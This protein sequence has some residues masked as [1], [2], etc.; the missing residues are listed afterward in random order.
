VALSAC[1]EKPAESAAESRDARVF[2]LRASPVQVTLRRDSARSVSSRVPAAGGAISAT[3]SDGSRFTLT[4]PPRALDGDTTITLTPISAL[5][6]LPLKGGLVAG[7]HL[8]PE[9]LRFNLPAVLRI[10]PAREAPVQQ[11][12][13]FGYLGGGDDFHAYPLDQGR[14]NKPGY[15]GV[16]TGMSFAQPDPILSSTVERTNYSQFYKK[17]VIKYALKVLP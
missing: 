5:G 8:E 14:E 17:G 16:P 2:P 6:G 3:G 10:E 9:G 4:A 7:V 12:V 11:Q 15:V 13:G 1:R